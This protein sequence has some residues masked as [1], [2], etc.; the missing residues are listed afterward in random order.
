MVEPDKPQTTVRRMRFAC[1]MAEA[2]YTHTHTHPRVRTLAHRILYVILLFH[3]NNGYANAPQCYVVRI[4]FVILHLRSALNYCA[5][6]AVFLVRTENHT[7]AFPVS[8]RYGYA[9]P[10]TNWRLLPN[11]ISTFVSH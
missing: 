6:L 3:G 1:W 10:P 5:S 4:W 2:T 8:V 9:R 11:C 7:T